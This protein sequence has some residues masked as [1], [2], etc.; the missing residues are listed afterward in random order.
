MERDE[1]IAALRKQCVERDEEI[2]ALRKQ[3]DRDACTIN[4]LT[5]SND[6]LQN[7]NN[8]KD[9]QITAMK[10]EIKGL[11]KESGGKRGGG[12][13]TPPSPDP[14]KNNGRILDKDN[15]HTAAVV[16]LSL[17]FHPCPDTEF[18][19][20]LRSKMENIDE[21]E[22]V[23]ASGSEDGTIRWWNLY[24]HEYIFVEE[25]TFRIY[26]EEKEINSQTK[27]GS[28]SDIS[29]SYGKVNC[30]VYYNQKL[31]SGSDNGKI[32]VWRRVEYVCNIPNPSDESSYLRIKWM[33]NDKE[34]SKSEYEYGEY[35]ILHDYIRYYSDEWCPY[36][37]LTETEYECE[38]ELT[39]ISH[40]RKSVRCLLVYNNKL[41]SGSGSD[42][43][44]WN[45]EGKCEHVFRGHAA[46]VNC[47]LV[48]KKK[49]YSGSGDKTIRVWNMDTNR[50]ENVLQGHTAAV[51]CL[52]FF[53]NRLYSGSNDKTIRFWDS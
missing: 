13:R 8:K 19:R 47:L 18:A 32:F 43:R 15:S 42:I 20:A 23:L 33:V 22:H 7:D 11:K 36:S 40:Y 48:D 24:T 29:Y 39:D 1:K 53:N 38:K 25:G 10:K 52:V 30:T 28:G 4:A 45:T 50:C 35:D 5:R 49:L 34:I 46:V 31:Y 14:K 3:C 12:S 9:S 2:A 17:N 16:C 37:F 27:V 21:S 44:V 51:N 6:L 41:Y 26:G